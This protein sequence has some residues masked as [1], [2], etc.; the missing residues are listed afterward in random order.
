M[1]GSA[2]GCLYDK[3]CQKI[4]HFVR[5]LHADFGHWYF[6]Y[7]E[8]SQ[9]A[10]SLQGRTRLNCSTHIGGIISSHKTDDH[11]YFRSPDIGAQQLICHTIDCLLYMLHLISLVP[12][13]VGCKQS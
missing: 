11:C 3:H 8:H 10:T 4:D 7:V 6:W 9:N 12:N 5:Q 13:P 1:S 2:S